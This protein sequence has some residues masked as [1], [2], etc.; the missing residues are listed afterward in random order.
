M[1]F[2]RPDLRSLL[3]Y[4][5][6]FELADSPEES[7]FVFRTPRGDERATA[8]EAVGPLS[9]GIRALSADDTVRAWATPAL[10]ALRIMARGALESPDASE[11]NELR[12]AARYIDV[13]ASRGQAK[14]AGFLK[15]LAADAPEVARTPQRGRTSEPP[16]PDEPRTFR[17]TLTISFLTEPTDEQVAVVRLKAQPRTGRSAA[18]D[19]AELFGPSSSTFNEDAREAASAML[20]RLAER[21]EPAARLRDPH[22]RGAVT[23]GTDEVAA[24]G[25]STLAPALMANHVEVVWPA[26]LV[27]ELGTSALVQRAEGPRSDRPAAFASG[28][29]FRFDWQVA[30]GSDVL[31]AHE[32]D[33]LAKSQHG[34]LRLRNRWVFVDKNDLREV[35]AR[36][37]HELSPFDALRAAVTGEIE[38]DGRRVD[39]QTVGWLDEVRER[40]MARGSGGHTV[41]QPEALDGTLRDYQLAGVG[42][43]SQLV[44]LGLGG[45]LADDMG[46]GKT[47]MLIALHLHRQSERPT[48]V[49]APASV[50]G[51]W[52]REVER[53]APDVPVVRYHGP[54][55]SLHGAGNGFVVTTYGTM[56]TDADVLADRAWGL[57]V[58]DEAQH[59]KNPRSRTAQALR[60]LEADA[61]LA[62]TGTPVENS[63][64]EL[65]AILD[66][67][68]PGL[69]GTHEEFRSSWSQPIESGRDR[70]RAATLSRLIR[71]FVLRRRK[72]DPGIAPELPPKIETDHHVNLTREQVGLYEAVVR[73]TMAQI[74]AAQ[75]IQR[76]GLVIRLL[77]QLK[78]ICNHPAQFLREGEGRL[79][80]RSGKLGVFDDLLTEILA[81]DGAVLVFTQYTQMGHLL[82]RHLDEQKIPHFFLHGHTPVRTRES[83]VRRFQAGEVPVFVLSLKAA[84][85]GL[86][87]TRA[88]HVVHYDRW[89]NPAVEDQATDR[90]H[91]IGQ[92]RAVQV[93]RLVA[94]GTVEESIA[95]LI[96]SKRSLADAVVNA[97]EGALTELT[98]AELADLVTLRRSTS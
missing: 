7:R 91:R 12:E 27:R 25:S 86:N 30:L 80:G 42:W 67:T 94:E 65:W 19:A 33:E 76:R 53:F 22:A 35:L 85:T 40:L 69:L 72:S 62:L 43:M 81:E 56:R 44:E 93:H 23:V 88:D 47:V 41:Q 29:L 8:N 55:R 57:V 82:A 87:L 70:E 46:L 28:Q 16:R 50:L 26:D 9:Q 54:G 15:A 73:D 89:W 97:G 34:L 31:S 49:V 63:L 51:N 18:I 20:G 75:G 84:G 61:N 4:P 66:W 48:L 1:V 21:W 5:V 96:S 79:T 45:V 10:V 90:A 78:Q 6:D 38:V 2:V 64:G 14:I 95:E 71:P 83:M 59:V 32:V 98:D 58:A 39:V 37:T 24:L 68:T 60:R 11:L 92:T 17:Y 52:V 3:R 74:E 77:T 13:D 36:R